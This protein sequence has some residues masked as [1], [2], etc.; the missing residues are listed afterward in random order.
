MT[1]CKDCRYGRNIKK[2]GA[3]YCTW[4]RSRVKP[5]G[6]CYKGEED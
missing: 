2:T 4:W 6:W 3:T 5:D 1:L